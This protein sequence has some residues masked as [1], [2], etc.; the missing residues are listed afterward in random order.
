M[1]GG[2]RGIGVRGGEEWWSE[3]MWS[4]GGEENWSG[5]G[6]V[7]VSPTAHPAT[8]NITAAKNIPVCL[9]HWRGEEGEAR[10]TV[11]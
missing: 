7:R 6:E 8:P 9:N 11:W 5:G 1:R 10:V 3:E 4:E 2:V